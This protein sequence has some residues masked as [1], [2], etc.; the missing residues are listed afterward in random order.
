[1]GGLWTV[2]EFVA[3][4]CA[5]PHSPFLTSVPTTLDLMTVEEVGVMPHVLRPWKREIHGGW[6]MH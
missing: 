5:K 4:T 6:V 1:M 3:H 2:C